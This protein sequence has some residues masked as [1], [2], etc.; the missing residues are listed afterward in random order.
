MKKS[1]KAFVVSI[2]AWQIKRL[3]K[4]NQFK[5]VGVVGSIGKTSTKLA[6]ARVLS[7]QLRVQYQEGNYNELVSVPLVF[8]GHK[9]PSL[10]NPFAW[11]AIFIKNEVILSKKYPYD[12]V[13]LEIGTDGP[14]QIAAFKQYLHLDIA[15]VT[16][17]TPEHMVYFS[18]LSAVAEEEL[19][20]AQYSKRLLLNVDLCPKELTLSYSGTFLSYSIKQDATYTMDPINYSEYGTRFTINKDREPWI[21]ADSKSFSQAQLY[22]LTA[23]AAV[24]DL[25][26]VPKEAIAEGFGKVVPVPGRLQL[27]Q[28]L[29]NST[30]IDDTYNASPDAVKGAL[31]ALYRYKAIRKIA[32]LGNMNE[33]GSTS[34]EAHTEVGSL[35]MPSQL[36]LLIT[37]GPDANEH[38]AA[39]AEKN[40]CKVARTNSP[41]EA[42]RVIL[43]VLEA[44]DVLLAKGSQN[45][46]YAE[47]AV[48]L[49]LENPADSSKLVRQSK[50]WIAKKRAQFKE[51][52]A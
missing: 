47:E 9:M 13:V 25:L 40:G 44:G 42:A 4:K 24:S 41:I 5:V 34:A 26:D 27:L 2:L 1:A 19:S 6:I 18:G 14:G 32:L 52:Q 7:E 31:D 3:Y 50:S 37:L 12:F 23:A 16:A 45:G 46:V 33:L 51:I 28:G 8:F 43:E 39:A 10:F 15:V 11:L 36:A 21:E 49:L 48:K 35:C 38:L 17:L 30:I 20:V 29:N 22:S